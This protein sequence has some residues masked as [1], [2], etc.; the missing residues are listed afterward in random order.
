M[1]ENKIPTNDS[2]A[3]VIPLHGIDA[4]GDP[5]RQVAYPDADDKAITDHFY[6]S[7]EL[8]TIEF[9]PSLRR[10]A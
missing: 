5:P 10:S 1:A 2:D 8:P 6:A 3:W 7:D 4:P 9:R